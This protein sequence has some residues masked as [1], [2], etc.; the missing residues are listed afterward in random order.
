MDKVI[1]ILEDMGYAHPDWDE[2]Q[3]TVRY[4]GGSYNNTRYKVKLA[5]GPTVCFS[6]YLVNRYPEVCAGEIRSIYSRLNYK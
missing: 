5:Q 2:V 3:E 6:A 1:D 4:P